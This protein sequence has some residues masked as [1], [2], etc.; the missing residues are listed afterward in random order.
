MPWAIEGWKFAGVSSAPALA[1]GEMV[2]GGWCRCWFRCWWFGGMMALEAKSTLE[3]QEARKEGCYTPEEIVGRRT[4]SPT[5][6]ER[7]MAME[8]WW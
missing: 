3:K 6:R 1:I 2:G 5:K 7:K 8:K 4:S